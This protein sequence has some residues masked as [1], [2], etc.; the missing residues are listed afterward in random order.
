VSVRSST[1][2][3]LIVCGRFLK[4]TAGFTS[5]VSGVKSTCGVKST[6]L[7]LSQLGLT[8]VVGAVDFQGWGGCGG[9]LQRAIEGS[10]FEVR[11]AV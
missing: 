11:N 5:Y 6:L 7:A 3:Y 1:I 2:Q 9:G 4:N 8:K 10:G